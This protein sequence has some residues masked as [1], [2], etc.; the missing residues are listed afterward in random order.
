MFAGLK[1]NFNRKGDFYMNKK[2]YLLTTALTMVVGLLGGLMLNKVQV[3]Q[4]VHAQVAEE[5]QTGVRKWEHCSI[6]PVNSL[7]QSAGKAT[8]TALISYVSGS[9]YRTEKVEATVDGGVSAMNLA[10]SNAL[11]KAVSKLGDEGWEMVGEGT[12]LP[13]SSGNQKVLYFRRSKK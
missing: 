2:M 4:P 3:M 12:L 9:G 11:A 10:T 13:D 1:T 5:N 8:G 6:L 7:S